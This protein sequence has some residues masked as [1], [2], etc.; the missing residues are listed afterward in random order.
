MNIKAK[1]RRILPPFLY[2]RLR[3]H[4]N[5]TLE[6]SYT[7]P[8]EMLELGN[9][10]YFLPSYALHRPAC[11]M[12]MDG[13]TYEPDTHRIVA[14][15]L[16]SLDG[17][18][19]HAGTFFGDMLPAFAATGKRIYAFEPVLENYVLARLC[20][21][22]NGLSNVLL[23]HSALGEGQGT[24]KMDVG[25]G[26]HKGGSS[27]VA[28]DGQI[29]SLLSIDSICPENIAVIQ[30]DVEGHEL[31]A[32]EGARETILR[33]NPVIMIE[34]NKAMCAPFLTELGYEQVGEIPG[35][36]IWSNGR[37]ISALL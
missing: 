28:D 14:L 36:R 1:I 37:D 19:V 23:Y 24:V 34:D 15:L 11:S 32:L 21:I 16:D 13:Q 17:N 6:G 18:L 31:P 29:T 33:D 26:K 4:S 8:Y 20:M 2:D 7:V 10:K 9:S 27:H 12:M 25:D 3:G 35:L 5:V 22:E 30:L